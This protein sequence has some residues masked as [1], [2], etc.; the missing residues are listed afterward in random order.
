[1]ERIILLFNTIVPTTLGTFRCLYFAP[2]FQFDSQTEMKHVPR[3]REAKNIFQLI[4]LIDEL[5]STF[6]PCTHK[7]QAREV[8]H[9]LFN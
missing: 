9:A 2:S 8:T 1:M 4:M 7:F 5:K 6:L 3:V